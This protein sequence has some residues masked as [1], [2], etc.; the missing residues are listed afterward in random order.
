MAE[1]IWEIMRDEGR[2]LRW[3]ARRAG[4]GEVHLY[5]VRAGRRHAT[6]RLRQACATALGRP[7]SELWLAD[8]EEV[9]A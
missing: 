8:R 7:A 1:P 9:T 5:E 2:T 6:A 4:Y 3:L